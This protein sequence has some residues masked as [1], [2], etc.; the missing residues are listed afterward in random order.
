VYLY[1]W[2]ISGIIHR[3]YQLLESDLLPENR[4][5]VAEYL[6]D[7]CLSDIEL[8][9]GNISDHYFSLVGHDLNDKLVEYTTSE[10]ARMQKNIEAVSY[11]IDDTNTLKLIIGKQHTVLSIISPSYFHQDPG[12]LIE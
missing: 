8:I 2:W 10:E 12:E 11:S 3:M 9:V 7:P 1:K 5:I 6:G 4:T